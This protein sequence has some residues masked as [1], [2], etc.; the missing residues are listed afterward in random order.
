MGLSQLEQLVMG[1]NKM[2]GNRLAQLRSLP[3]L[4]HLDLSGEQRTDSNLW[5]IRLNDLDLD[6]IAALPRL[7]VLNLGG[8][9]IT[10]LGVAKLKTLVALQSLDL[11]ETQVTGTGLKTV[12]LLPKLERLRLWKAGKIDDTALQPLASI[13]HLSF[14]DLAET[15]VTDKGLEHLAGMKQLRQLFLGGTQVTSAGVEKFQQDHPTCQVSRFA[16]KSEPKK[17][18][19]EED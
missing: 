18:V 10:D 16:T 3:A 8:R 7:R 5:G 6:H 2:G 15:A 4:V 1:G 17:E 11:S 12:A 19:D 14:L 9:K 13:K